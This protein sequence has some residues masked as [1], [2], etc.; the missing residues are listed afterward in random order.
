[1]IESK[2]NEFTWPQEHT[3]ISVQDF[4]SEI[5]FLDQKGA[6][7]F[8]EHLHK[9]IYVEEIEDYLVVYLKND[10]DE[11][12]VEVIQNSLANLM[13]KLKTNQGKQL[14]LHVSYLINLAFV[15]YIS[16]NI[17]RANIKLYFIGND[18]LLSRNAYLELKNRLD[19]SLFVGFKL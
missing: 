19:S 4:D 18:I 12:Y 8:R 6:V 13:Q 2:K 10:N 11:V 1:L 3:G 16:G 17:L 5:A 9:L 15:E 14:Y 7:I